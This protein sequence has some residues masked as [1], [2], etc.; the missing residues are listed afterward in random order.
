MLRPA[1]SIFGPEM[2]ARLFQRISERFG[3]ML[4]G[5]TSSEDDAF[6]SCRAS[7]LLTGKVAYAEQFEGLYALMRGLHI[8]FVLAGF[9]YIGLIIGVIY[10]DCFV[11]PY[12][13]L[14][15]FSALWIVGTRGKRRPG[16]DARQSTGSGQKWRSRWPERVALAG[17]FTVAGFNAHRLIAL[18]D[19]SVWI[20]SSGILLCAAIAIKCHEGYVEWTVAFVTTVY[21][22][23]LI[24]ESAP[25]TPSA[26]VL[27]T[28]SP[29]PAMGHEPS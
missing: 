27:P 20:L 22:D 13:L 26:A 7:L 14:L 1:E 19:Y 24:A 29:S 5:N 2:Q 11:V 23:F 12:L 6:Y 15:G 17:I 21:R 28:A 10:G 16:R 9:F 4:P 25:H 3:L 18:P 8:A